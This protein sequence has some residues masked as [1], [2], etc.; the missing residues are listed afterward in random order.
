MGRQLEEV[1]AIAGKRPVFVAGDIFHRHN[2]PPKLVNFA[3][4]SLPERVY[5]VAGNHDL[6]NHNLEDIQDSGFATLVLNGRIHHLDVAEAIR[7]S[8]GAH[9]IASGF[10][11]GEPVAPPT[12][13]PEGRVLLCVAHAYIWKDTSTSFPGADKE[14]H[15]GR[16]AEKLKGYH[17]AVFGDNHKPFRFTT[18]YGTEVINPGTFFRMNADEQYHAPQVGLLLRDGTIVVWYLQSC[19]EDKFSDG[20]AIEQVAVPVLGKSVQ[21]FL[22]ELRTV[23]AGKTDLPGAI[24]TLIAKFQGRPAV[25]AY[26]RTVCEGLL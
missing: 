16:Y 10:S 9:I 13:S 5:A 18:V 15:A 23:S 21:E 11:W 24:Q 22:Q 12:M 8:R 4:R 14:L 25:A 17:A 1:C 3:H 2:P 6:P 19:Q 26:L 20:D 7:T